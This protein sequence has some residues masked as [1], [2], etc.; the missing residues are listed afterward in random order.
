VGFRGGL[1]DG[2]GPDDVA[3]LKLLPVIAGRFIAGLAFETDNF[4]AALVNRLGR[5]SRYHRER[6]SARKQ[7]IY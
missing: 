5:E 7:T 1:N 6:N 3:D 2:A 4:R